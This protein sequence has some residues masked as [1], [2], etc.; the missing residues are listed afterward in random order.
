MDKF[1][2][3]GKLTSGM[4]PNER[5]AVVKD[6][7]GRGWALIVPDS[8]VHN[9]GEEGFIEVQ[10]VERGGKVA[11]VRL[12]G[13]VFGSAR[14]VTVDESELKPIQPILVNDS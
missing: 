1:L 10:V 9:L 5:C 12:P 8:V 6:H 7:M 2:L 13:E 4:F 3:K 11:L 14:T